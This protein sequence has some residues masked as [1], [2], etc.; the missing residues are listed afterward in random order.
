MNYVKSLFFNFLIVFFANHILPGIHVGSLTKLP[1]VRADLL[2][3]LCLGL[4]N[5]WIYPILR[6]FDPKIS[7]LH[8]AGL[9]LVLNFLSYAI[10]KVLS[11]GIEIVTLE[12]YLFVSIVVAAGSFILNYLEMRHCLKL[13]KNEDPGMPQ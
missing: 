5:S 7:W 2:F 4:L 11:I 9:A 3:P 8:I 12:G 10:L 6:I 1:H 13:P